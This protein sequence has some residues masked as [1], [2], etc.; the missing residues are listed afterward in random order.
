MTRDVLAVM[1]KATLAVEGDRFERLAL[2]VKTFD[3]L[4]DDVA[5]IIAAHGS[6]TRD[7]VKLRRKVADGW[8]KFEKHH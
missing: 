7:E 2:V 5:A 4:K 3:T 8:A 6:D 1:D